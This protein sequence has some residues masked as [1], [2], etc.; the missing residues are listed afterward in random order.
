MPNQ[1]DNSDKPGLLH[2]V[3]V[4]AAAVF[5]LASLSHFL[6]G[7]SMWAIESGSM[8]PNM[9]MGDLVITRGVPR[10][11]IVT[12]Q[13][14]AISG[15]ESFGEFGDVV[16]YRKYGR[17]GETPI[18]HRAMY[19]VDAGEPMWEKGPPAPH[20]GYITK[21]DHNSYSDQYCGVC[22][23]P[24]REE[25]VIGVARFRVPYAGYVRLACLRIS[26]VL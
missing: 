14:G 5:L 10:T 21:G 25:W 12:Y 1:P 23:E 16:L 11:G 4:V 8:D 3:V 13:D 15:Y 19:Y 26:G 22:R 18:I 20:A 7:V 2:Y 24:I 17:N 6:L 9:R